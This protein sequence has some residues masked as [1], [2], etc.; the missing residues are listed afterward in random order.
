MSL[1]QYAD[2]DVPS[3]CVR[4]CLMHRGTGYCLGCYRTLDEIAAWSGLTG[5]QKRAILARLPQR[6]RVVG[7]VVL[8]KG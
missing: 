4:V 1:P 7:N 3:P 6:Q 2:D 8:D 5:E